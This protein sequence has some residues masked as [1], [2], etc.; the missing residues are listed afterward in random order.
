MRWQ[1]EAPERRWLLVQEPALSQ[2]VDRAEAEFAGI[3]NRRRWWLVPA[4]AADPTCNPHGVL[5]QNQ[6]DDQDD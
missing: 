1:A 5:T 2:C 3:A 6:A 4:A